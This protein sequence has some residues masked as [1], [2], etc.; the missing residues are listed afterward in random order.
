LSSRVHA[1][2]TKTVTPADPEAESLLNTAL[3]LLRVG[4]PEEGRTRLLDNLYRILDSLPDEHPLK[5]QIR[6]A[7]EE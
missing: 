2:S 4:L 5:P 3:T 6:A 7:V 1:A